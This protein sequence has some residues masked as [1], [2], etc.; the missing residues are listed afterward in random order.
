MTLSADT[1][2]LTS[3]S[4][5]GEVV[6]IVRNT[7]TSDDAGFT[8]DS[9]ASVATP[10]GDLQPISNFSSGANMAMPIGQQRMSSHR[11]FLPDGTDVKQGDRIRP[12]GWSAGDDEYRVDAVLDDEGHIEARLSLVVGAA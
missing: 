9:W 5:W 3:T 2:D 12:Y 1:V 6:T 10:N 7:I 11:I 8:T 4:L